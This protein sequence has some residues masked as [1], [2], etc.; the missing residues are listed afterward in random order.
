M[1]AIANSHANT[2]SE[3][4][5]QYGRTLLCQPPA[6]HLAAQ[7]ELAACVFLLGEGYEVFRNVSA[8]GT[9]DIVACKG[10][11]VLRIDVKSARHAKLT[12]EQEK[13]GIIILYIDEN[14]RCEFDF[15]RKQRI[16]KALHCALIEIAGLSPK[17]GA[18]QLNKQGIVTPNGA[19][20]SPSLV[21]LMRE[22]I[23]L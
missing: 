7:T 10:S 12:P 13:E 21:V 16:D 2:T 4:S 6:K 11:E 15:D 8:H 23:A 1:E 19:A 17:Q 9:A 5:A 3:A 18:E 20:W 14:G 22:R